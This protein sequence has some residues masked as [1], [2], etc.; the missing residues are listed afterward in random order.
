MQ[1]ILFIGGSLNQTRMVHA[2]AQHLRTGYDCYFTPYYCDG[3]FEWAARRGWLNFTVI[4]GNARLQTEAYLRQHN[5]PIDY[6]GRQHNYDM[7]VTTSDLIIQQNI[8]NKKI[9]LIQEGMTDRESLMFYLV[10]WFKIPRYLASTATNG[11]SD[12]YRYFCVAS[13]GYRDHFIQKGIKPEKI[14]VTGIPN[15]DHCA[16]FL[17]NDFPYKDYVLVAT[18]DTRETFKLASR[19]KFLRRALAIAAGRP[20]I[21]KLHPNENIRRA[22]REIKALAPEALIFTTENIEPMIA[23]CAV[24]ITQFSTVVYIGLAL[25]KEV[26]SYFDV[27]LLKRLTPVQNGGA[28]AGHIAAV[29][30]RVLAEESVEITEVLAYAT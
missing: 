4:G 7:V 28:S 2:V 16:A 11:L 19:R 23:N 10:K 22:T 14:L 26:Y 12:A 30:R 24:L 9:I 3:L 21:F 1:K 8:R 17:D 25:G 15:F 27:E 20:L 5:L 29:C 6:G 13:A 18:S